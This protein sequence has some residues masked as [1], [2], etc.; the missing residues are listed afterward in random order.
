M[1]INLL[2]TQTY[3]WEDKPTMP[4][5]EFLKG[6]KLEVAMLQL[7][8]NSFSKNML[9]THSVSLP[10]NI[11]ATKNIQHLVQ[12]YQNYIENEWLGLIENIKKISNNKP[13]F[14][15]KDEGQLLA[16]NFQMVAGKNLG[17]DDFYGIGDYITLTNKN[18]KNLDVVDIL[19]IKEINKIMTIS[20][21]DALYKIQATALI[22]QDFFFGNNYKINEFCAAYKLYNN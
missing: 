2:E 12:N 3:P 8:L 9:W 15:W 11:E 14:S 5:F 22:I 18:W 21:I 17:I 19:E 4:G 16:D 20:K 10:V 1:I 6:G 7:D 13:I